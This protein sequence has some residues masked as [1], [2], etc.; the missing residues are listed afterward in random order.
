MAASLVCDD[1][2]VA[3]TAPFA[4]DKAG[5]GKTSDRIRVPDDCDDPLVLIR[6]AANPAG[7]GSYFAVAMDD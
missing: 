6:N 3:S 2:V 7:L 1:M 5:N 4:V